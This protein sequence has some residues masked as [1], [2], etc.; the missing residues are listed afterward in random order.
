MASSQVISL[1]WPEPRWPVRCER[2]LDAVGM[3]GDLQRGL[4]AGTELALIDGVR[5]I[6]FD[7]FREAHFQDAELA[8]ADDFGL[9]LHDADQSAAAGGAESADARLPGGDSRQQILFG[10]EADELVVGIAATFQSSDC[11]GGRRDSYEV[12]TLHIPICRLW[13]VAGPFLSKA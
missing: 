12:S 13:A 4:S 8:V 6:A 11:A 5:G 9:A 7:L 1:N 2:R 10:D 3:I